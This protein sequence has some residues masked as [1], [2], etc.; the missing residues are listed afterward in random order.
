MLNKR[1]LMDTLKTM[2]LG[3]SENKKKAPG[4]RRFS[5]KGGG[6]T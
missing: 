6:T 2:P 4:K 1:C 3:P 5:K